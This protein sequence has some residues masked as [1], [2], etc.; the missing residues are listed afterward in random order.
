[1]QFEMPNLNTQSRGLGFAIGGAIVA[2]VGTMLL[3]IHWLEAITG[4]TGI[5]EMFPSTAA[6]LGD[7]AR[8]LIAF[9]TGVIVFVLLAA[10]L[11]KRNSVE[12]KASPAKA[13]VS[14]ETFGAENSDAET[15]MP[16]GVSLVSQLRAKATAALARLR[17]QDVSDDDGNPLKLRNRDIHPDAPARR[18]IS[19]NRDFAD[20]GGQSAAPYVP[21]IALPTGPLVQKQKAEPAI[22]APAHV[23]PVHVAPAAAPVASEPDLPTPA[24]NAEMDL[25]RMV[26]NLEAVLAERSAKLERLE[27]IA[28]RICTQSAQN[29]RPLDIPAESP[30]ANIVSEV[31]VDRDAN[32]WA[33]RRLA[34]VEPTGSAIRQPRNG[35]EALRSALE[36]LHRMNARSG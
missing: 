4:V 25:P 15:A 11:S 36:T 34:A 23:A 9:M 10:R 14:I 13:A 32:L 8:A 16:V 24:M 21:E 5:S 26:D 27:N 18:P 7:T 20:L 12:V 17:G 6:P 28:Q 1:M 3:P 2:A 33:E 29:G 19:A 35:D 30:D 31:T 22:V